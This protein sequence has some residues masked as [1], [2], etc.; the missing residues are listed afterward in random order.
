MGPAE[1][2]PIDVSTKP[3][4]LVRH[5]ACFD[6]VQLCR[7]DA[8]AQQDGKIPGALFREIAGNL[9]GRRRGSARGSSAPR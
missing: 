7:Q 5:E 2:P 3:L 1:I 6:D 9:T 4:E 8:G